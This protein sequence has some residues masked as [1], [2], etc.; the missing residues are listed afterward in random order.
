MATTVKCTICNNEYEVCN[1]CLEQKTFKPWRTVTDT[2]GHYKIYLAIHGY[3]VSKNKLKARKELK[4]CDLSDLEYFK[5]EIK[6]V[7]KE[8]MAEQKKNK[9]SFKKTEENT[10]EEIEIKTN[11]VDE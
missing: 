5:P 4:N 8:I 9:I 2:I 6:N 1:S 11:I 7:I 10:D 3:T